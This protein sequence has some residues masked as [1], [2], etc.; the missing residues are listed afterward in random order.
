MAAIMPIERQLADASR[1][2]TDAALTEVLRPLVDE[3]RSDPR[4]LEHFRLAS[5][6]P[7]ERIAT[8]LAEYGPARTAA[9]RA[10]SQ[11]QHD[12][13]FPG[14]H[15][16]H[17][18]AA[19]RYANLQPLK[20]QFDRADQAKRDFIRLT[21]SAAMKYQRQILANLEHKHQPLAADVLAAPTAEKV[22]R[23]DAITALYRLCQITDNLSG[24]LEELLTAEGASSP[25]DAPG[26]ASM[27]V[28]AR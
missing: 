17:L 25:S 5:E 8:F 1:E 21:Q 7:A 13:Y 23:L 26:A 12:I 9:L 22:A 19:A 24:K 6:W 3:L 11:Q 15:A 27:E 28:P 10:K 20:E 16:Q 4:V 18:D 2:A 14:I